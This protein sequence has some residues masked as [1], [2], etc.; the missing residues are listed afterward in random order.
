MNS[1]IKRLRG[2]VSRSILLV[3]TVMLF[4]G[5]V[6]GP[7]TA[8]ADDIVL[9]WNEIA[10]RTA[11]ATTP[12]NQARIGAI[13]QLAVFEAVNAVTGDYEP[14]LHPPTVAPAGTSVDAAVITAA[15]RV[16]TTYFPAPATVAM[17]DAARDSDLAAIP[18]GPAKTN[19]I[20]V[21]MGAANAMIAL[22]AADGSSP[23][24]T[25]I[26]TPTLPGDY[27]LTTGCAAG[28]FYNWQ[29]VTTFGIANAADFLLSPPPYLTSNRYTKDYAEVKTV[30]ANTSAD[31]P[32]DREDVVRLYA[33]SSP[34]FVLSMATRQIAAAK[35]TS[36]S[37]NARALALINMAISDALVASF[38]NK[39]H[40]NHWRPET[41]IRNGATDG[42]DKTEGDPLFT[43]FIP[44]P[45]FPSYPSN[46]A[47]GTNGGLEAMRRLFG[48][49]GHDITI[50][51]TVPAL[52]PLPATVITRYYTQL[53]EIG[54]DVDDARVYG[55]IHWRYDQVAGNVLGRA[56]GTEVVKNNLRPVHPN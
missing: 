55:G 29:N 7:A 56:I 13:V 20:A 18:A 22:R 14:Y 48:A 12:F 4:V 24:T 37:E 53:K 30:G 42:N 54:D 35:G 40:Y 49:A 38:G 50:A 26:P 9:R 23:L 16:L 31:R 32:A 27:G 21:G 3:S 51:N 52:G 47:S 11:T 28:L 25:I 10:A 44:T 45:C 2:A 19:G 36:L 5:L 15:H 39:Y 41:G 8:R 17:L 6:S 34:S 33:T 1:T 43:T 46:H